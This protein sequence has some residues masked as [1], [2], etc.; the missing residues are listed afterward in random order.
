MNHTEANQI[1][2]AFS[3]KDGSITI[4]EHAGWYI[5]SPLVKVAYIHT[6]PVRVYYSTLAR[7][8]T[9][10]LVMVKRDKIMDYIAHQGFSYDMGYST[11]LAGY[12][13]SPKQYDF[14]QVTE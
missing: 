10:H 6:V 3:S 5:T 14:I 4:Q 2:V 8:Q 11:T 9:T 7:V 12:V 1:G 13:F